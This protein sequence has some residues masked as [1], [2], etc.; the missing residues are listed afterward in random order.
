MA[1]KKY[2]LAFDQGTS[3]SRSLLFDKNFNVVA[4]EQKELKNYYP[5]KNH[6]EQNPEEIFLTQSE[7]AQ[8]L[9][10]KNKIKSGQIAAVGIT[11]QRETTILWNKKTGKP[12]YNAIVWQDK[13]TTDICEF[14]NHK[15]GK[16]YIRETTGLITDAYFS[17]TKIS[18]IL[19]NV[20]EAKELAEKDKLLFGTVDTW[21]IWNLTKGKLHI[22]D[23]SNASR[24]MLFDINKLTWDK[25]ILETLEIPESILPDVVNS[26][27]KYGYI[28]KD[29]FGE[30]IALGGI[31]GDQQAS[32]FGQRCFKEGEGK[33]TYGT[34]CFILMNTGDKLL[35]SSH[36]LI[37]TIAWGINGKV[38]YA[39]EGS[40]FVGGAVVKWLRDSLKMIDTAYETEKI[41]VRAED[42]KKVYFVPAFNGL[43]APYWDANA[44]G[45]ITGL[46]QGVK[47]EH[48]VRAALESMAYQTYDVINAMNKDSGIDLKF[49]QV[50]GG[51]SENNF[52]MQFQ[53]DILNVNI[54]RP[55]NLEITALGAA[56]LAGLS[57][58]FWTFDEII[59]RKNGDKVFTPEISE[60]KRAELLKGWKNAVSR[61]KSR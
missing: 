39:V 4:S 27:D 55:V 37:N 31:A 32:L 57:C 35:K 41:A 45:I 14:L 53:A 30:K 44:E 3:S 40:V 8:V 24:T 49:L 51:A 54:K 50:D 6:V 9:L 13:R 2:I 29:I 20:P 21:L 16:E 46:T 18:W 12:V 38:K 5:K 25:T 26:S 43:G 42:N 23:Y 61:C 15:L 60:E 17:A 1:E 59:Q 48:I 36:G 58:G 22:T 47:K 7:T 34:G 28:D 19:K 33:N 56:L 10:R 11:N 52:L